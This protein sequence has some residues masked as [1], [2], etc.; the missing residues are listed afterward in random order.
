MIKFVVAALWIAAVTVGSVY[1]SFNMLQQTAEETPEPSFFGGLDYVRTDMIS[2]PLLRDKKVEGYFLARLVYTVEPEKLKKL[3]LPV[4]AL[5]MDQV[6]AYLYANPHIDFVNRTNLDLDALRG[7]IRDS[8]NARVGEKLVHEVLIEQ[9][10]FLTRE[11][12][13]E[14]TARRRAVALGAAG[15]EVPQ[16][17]GH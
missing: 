3:S 2:V 11:D 13:R 9:L 5:L 16:N 10:D 17:G 15:K 1:Y 14:N 12:I 7:G 4:D 6:Y 8:V